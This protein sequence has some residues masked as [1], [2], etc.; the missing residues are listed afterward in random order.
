MSETANEMEFDAL[1]MVPGAEYER[2][3]RIRERQ[4]RERKAKLYSTR[5]KKHKGVNS[6]KTD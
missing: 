4:R 2:L 1:V 6:R 3:A 5:A